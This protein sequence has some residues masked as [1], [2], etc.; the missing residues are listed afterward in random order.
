MSAYKT[1]MHIK[2]R[3]DLLVHLRYLSKKQNKSMTRIIEEALEDC[4][5]DIAQELTEAKEY[6]KGYDR[7]F[8]K[9]PIKRKP[10]GS[11]KQ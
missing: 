10:N 5:A 6:K 7:I 9:V 11:G 2:M 3:N 1:S 4:F 8:K